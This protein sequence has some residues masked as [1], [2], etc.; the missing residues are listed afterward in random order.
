[1][2]RLTLWLN[3]QDFQKLERKAKQAGVSRWKYLR[4]AVLEKLAE[5]DKPVLPT[6]PRKIGKKQ[7]PL[8]HS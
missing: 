4:Q 1:M 2:P 5:A 8:H 6:N 7:D 3:K